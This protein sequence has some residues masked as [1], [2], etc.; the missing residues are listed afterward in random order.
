MSNELLEKVIRT[1]EVGA[2]GGG[3][4]NA[5][6]ADRF[7]DYM[8]DATVLGSQVRTIRMRS[9]EVDIDKVGVGERL[10]RVATEAVDDGVN[11]GAVFTKISLTTKKLRLDWELSTESLEDNLEGEALEDHIAR[12]MATQAGNDI[13]DVAINGNTAL[14]SDP[15]MKAFDG[16]RKLAL[17]GGHVVD[18]A[19]QPLNRA[20][21]NKALK[22]MPRKYMQRRNGLKFFT[23]SNLIQDYL[24]GL[25][26]T[27]SGLISLE[28]VAEGVTRNGVRTEGPAG[29]TSTPMFGIPTQEV[30]LFL[31]TVDGDYSGATGDHG[32]LWLTFPQNMLWGVKREI[33][34]YR[35]FK[36]KK[37]TIEYTMYC[38]VGT[39][40]ENADA[41][42]VVKNIKVSS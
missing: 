30:P 41:F 2:G 32:D 33:Q 20:A 39:Q 19:G 1:T 4:L 38:R 3:L 31:E 16:W 13:E 14:T 25:T 12:L 18:H 9:T 36:P 5:E 21:A 37:D 8:W 28:N 24:Y 22:A 40:I 23:G 27:A 17:A 6:Q 29:F 26:Q 42:V 11:A 35:E 34:V 15:L 7:I 10:M